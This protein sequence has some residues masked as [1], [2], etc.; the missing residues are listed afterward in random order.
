M[1]KAIDI[2]LLVMSYVV[3][4]VALGVHDEILGIDTILLKI[5][6]VLLAPIHVH[7]RLKRLLNSHVKN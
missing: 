4:T 1:H 2:P 5:F 7:F 3:I 6:I